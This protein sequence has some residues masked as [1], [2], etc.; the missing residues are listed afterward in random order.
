MRFRDFPKGSPTK[1]DVGR[2]LFQIS[3]KTKINVGGLC[4]NFLFCLKHL[5]EFRHVL[6]MST[7]LWGA[8]ICF[9]PLKIHL[10]RR[11]Q[12]GPSSQVFFTRMAMRCQC[13]SLSRVRHRK[14]RDSDCLVISP[15]VLGITRG[16]VSSPRGLEYVL[17]ASARRV[18]RD[19]WHDWIEL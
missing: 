11:S 13:F 4:K 15:N 17:R 2:Y 6:D 9:S 18:F 8:L 3:L 12:K 10:D 7:S 16:S 5:N 19:C 14:I 1:A